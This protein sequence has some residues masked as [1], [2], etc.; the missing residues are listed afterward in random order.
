M[1]LT[2]IMGISGNTVT[3]SPGLYMPNWLERAEIHG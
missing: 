1:Q 2:E 3:I